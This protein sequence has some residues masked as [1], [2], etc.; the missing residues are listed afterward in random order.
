VGW[1]P[2]LG[3]VAIAVLVLAN[4]FFVA[5]EF[6]IVAVRRSRLE[7]LAAEGDPRAKLARH[8]VEHLGSYIAACQ[9]GITM[10]SLALGWIGEPAFARLI[11][12][13]LESLVGRFAPAAAHGVAV[14]ISFALITGITIVAGELTPKG[15]ALQRPDETTLRIARPM[16]LFYLVFR[17]PITALTAVGNATLRL[18]GLRPAAGH[19]MVHSVEE[20]ELLVRA[21]QQAGRV[22][23]SEARIAARAFQFADLTASD[24][25]TPRTEL[26]AVPVSIAFADLVR[27]VGRGR[28]NRVLVYDRSLDD[29]LGVVRVRELFSLVPQPPA[30]FDLRPLIRPVLTVPETR[31]ADDLLE[32]MRRAGRHLAVVVD[33]YG[34][35]AGIVT[36]T[37]L[38]GALVGRIDEEPAPDQPRLATPAADGSLLLGGL[39]R[40][41]EL[42]ELLG[43]ELDPEAR[44]EVATLGGLVMARLDRMPG[45]GDEVRIAGRRLRIEQL[46]GRRV[47]LVRLFPPE[48]EPAPEPGDQPG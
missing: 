9:L 12:P 24:L 26:G 17:W 11:E 31:A 35:T 41:G 30:P 33:E 40:V 28:H 46:D 13:P 18:L 27:H 23:E 36:L 34:G 39:L 38:L 15:I 44:A 22:E 8:I 45:V 2:L 4:G 14:G 10:A 21:S 32:D 6:A 47:A 29:I 7:Q 48:P 1:S 20:L 3:L 43:T 19:E 5:A 16:H 42:E 25:M 37:D